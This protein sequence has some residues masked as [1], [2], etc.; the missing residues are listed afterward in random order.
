[1]NQFLDRTFFLFCLVTF[2]WSFNSWI[3][4]WYWWSNSF[5]IIHYTTDITCSSIECINYWLFSRTK[6]WLYNECIHTRSKY[7]WSSS[8]F[9]ITKDDQKKYTFHFQAMSNEEILRLLN[10]STES[11]FYKKIVRISKFLRTY[12]CFSLFRN[13][14]HKS[15]VIPVY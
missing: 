11:N 9:R 6:I 15:T 3:T 2:T 8:R 1:M 4:W 13:P 14:M 12:L 7:S 5:F 10:I